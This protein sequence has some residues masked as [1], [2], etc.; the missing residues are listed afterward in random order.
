MKYARVFLKGAD[1]PLRWVDVPL[2]NGTF[3]GF[4]STVRMDGCIPPHPDFN[5]WVPLDEIKY[6]VQIETAEPM[7]VPSVFFAEGKPN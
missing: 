2:G 1:N 7:P 6:M 4:C 3:T 5:V